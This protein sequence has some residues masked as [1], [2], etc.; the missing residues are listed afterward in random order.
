MQQQLERT[1]A[2][3]SI[4]NENLCDE[5][6]WFVRK[7]TQRVSCRDP[8][9]CMKPRRRRTVAVSPACPFA[10]VCELSGALLFLSVWSHCSFASAPLCIARPAPSS[11]G[12]CALL[13][14]LLELRGVCGV[15]LAADT[16]S[17]SRSLSLAGTLHSHAVA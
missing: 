12:W 10:F 4:N 3:S 7:M 8:R 15:L 16:Y 11:A 13:T 17:S 2:N 6:D 14:G 1:Q 9:N 5:S